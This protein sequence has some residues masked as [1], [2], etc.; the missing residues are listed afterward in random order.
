MPDLVQRG[1]AA[2]MSYRNPRVRVSGMI[3]HHGKLLLVCQ[4]RPTSPRW[5]MPGGGVDPGESLT[6]ALARELREEIQCDRCA[7]GEPVALVESIAPESHASG[8]HLI[9]M[10]FRV[11]VPDPDSICTGAG[12]GS[13]PAIR[14]VRWIDRA[15]LLE[16]AIHPP[17]GKYLSSYQPGDDFQ[18]FGTLWA[19]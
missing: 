11:D 18:Y 8:R 7:V 6:V 10:V 16:T 12:V 9:H 2:D 17:I 5:M 14:E 4:G 19:P 1:F 13:D 15:E 3:W